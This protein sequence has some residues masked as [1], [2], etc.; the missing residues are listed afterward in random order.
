MLFFASAGGDLIITL[1]IA[2]M[3]APICQKRL[4][5]LCFVTAGFSCLFIFLV[6]LLCFVNLDTVVYTFMFLSQ[7]GLFLGLSHSMVFRFD[8]HKAVAR[9]GFCNTSIQ[10]YISL[11]FYVRV[12]SN[13]QV[14]TEGRTNSLKVS[15]HQDVV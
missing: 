1:K 10:Y 11:Q 13:K 15:T 14:D 3:A 2:L 4:L 6:C 5:L 12:L 9:L 8:C 7:I